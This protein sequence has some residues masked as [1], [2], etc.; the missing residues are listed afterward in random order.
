[1]SNVQVPP[2]TV[3][4][5]PAHREAL[6]RARARALDAFAVA[7]ALAE[8]LSAAPGIDERQMALAL[9]DERASQEAFEIVD[10]LCTE[11]DPDLTEEAPVPEPIE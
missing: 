7:S 2:T 11:L 8:S 6:Q 1:M 4:F 9:V 5:T 10:R 3:N